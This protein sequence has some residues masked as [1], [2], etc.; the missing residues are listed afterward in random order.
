L[1]ALTEELEQRV[2][3]S[4]VGDPGRLRVLDVGCGD[5]AYAMRAAQAGGDVLGLDRSRPMLEAARVRAAASGLVV[6]WCQ[7]QA[8]ALPFREGTFDLVIAVTAL[9]LISQPLAALNEMS[10]VLRPGGV[11]VVGELGRWSLWAVRRRFR[12]WLGDQLW[13][14]A[15]FWT[16]AELRD[17]LATAGLRTNEMRGAVYYPPSAAVAMLMSPMEGTMRHLGGLG[18][19]FIA[20]RATKE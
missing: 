8:Q 13:K 12:G 1:G 10:R 4:L 11:V 5:G 17:L 16:A 9:C 7:G 6:S 19:A 15:R 20:M 3:F 18:A 14:T 2:I